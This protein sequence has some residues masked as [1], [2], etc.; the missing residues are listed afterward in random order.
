MKFAGAALKLLLGSSV[1]SGVVAL[2][3]QAG[4]DPLVT[5]IVNALSIEQ[6]SFFFGG[7]DP[8]KF[9]AN[10]VGFTLGGGMNISDPRDPSGRSVF[11]IPAIIMNDGPQGYRYPKY[12]SIIMNDGPQ[13]FR[14]R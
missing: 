4:D 13:A 2:K 12:L 5:M 14:Y 6:K 7:E 3:P 9:V 8:S 10:Y 1:L 11:R